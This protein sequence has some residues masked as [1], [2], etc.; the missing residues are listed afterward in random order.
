M[1]RV[2]RSGRIVLAVVLVSLAGFISYL[3][4][5]QPLW[6]VSFDMSKD[7][8]E[9]LDV[10]ES[11]NIL[12]AKYV[13]YHPENQ[14]QIEPKSELRGYDLS[15]GQMVWRLPD[16]AEVMKV[17][18]R[19]TDSEIVIKGS[20]ELRYFWLSPDRSRVACSDYG[21]DIQL[22]AFP[23]C[24]LQ[25]RFKVPDQS[26]SDHH[27]VTYF[28]DGSRFLVWTE[29]RIYIYDAFSAKLI[30][31]LNIPDLPEPQHLED[32]LPPEPE[33]VET[34]FPLPNAGKV[35]STNGSWAMCNEP[36]QCSA[37]GSYLAI[38]GKSMNSILV[39]H[40]PSKKLISQIPFS[41]V[42]RFLDG[43]VLLLIPE[44]NFPNRPINNQPK[45][46]AL[47]EHGVCELPNKE[48]P[49]TVVGETLCCDG[50]RLVTNEVQLNIPTS[51]PFWAD[52]N[53]L[54][55]GVKM[56]LAMMLVAPK[57]RFDIY[58]VET[59]K[60]E[61]TFFLPLS[62]V[63]YSAYLQRNWISSNGKLLALNDGDSLAVWEITPLRPLPCWLIL[64]G[65]ILFSLWL[66]W[67][68]QT[69]ATQPAAS[70]HAD[71]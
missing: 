37:D 5:P 66:A 3:W 58:G 31:M 61:R 36:I 6:S 55:D 16:S 28:R 68:R 47:Y 70:P 46:Y 64:V 34:P 60:H 35:P 45:R 29:K 57:I 13:D 56:K 71:K 2:W 33:K 26:P 65:T 4:P 48:T 67:P 40:L 51:R 21:N 14:P 44:F 20:E 42:P 15:T 32:I 63:F 24:K 38:P 19:L 52:W 27:F 62:Y 22:R 39:F 50:R 10:D 59:G 7:H 23:S 43:N 25:H 11:K 53:W 54:S 69:K 9:L 8:L 1:K 30:D 18:P 41:G 49:A 17:E 12:Y